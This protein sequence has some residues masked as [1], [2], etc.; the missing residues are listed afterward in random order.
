MKGWSF[1]ALVKAL[2]AAAFMDV[3]QV[4]GTVCAGDDPRFAGRLINK[5]KYG[6]SLT[7]TLSP[8]AGAKW[9]RV[10]IGAGGG[11]GGS[12]PVASAANTGYEGGGGGAGAQVEVWIPASLITS[13]VTITLGR[14]GLND[15]NTSSLG[16]KSEFG[17]L[18]SCGGG[19]GGQTAF[20]DA[21]TVAQ[22]A[23]G[24]AGG[25]ATISSSI[26]DENIVINT[27]GITGGQGFKFPFSQLGGDGGPSIFGAG[28]RGAGNASPSDDSKA[29]SAG[30][31]GA[32]NV[33]PSAAARPGGKGANGFC[34]VEVYS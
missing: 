34:L 26:A 15:G 2:K 1:N 32:A 3:G 5:F 19:A 23:L 22:L 8:V 28:G 24:G 20:W 6:A 21:N 33:G 11:S 31:G 10:R 30:G 7:N 17:S 16:E 18:I 4:A 29:P 25:L 27:R 9:Y 14:G 13:D 12:C